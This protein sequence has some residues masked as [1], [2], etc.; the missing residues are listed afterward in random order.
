MFSVDWFR[1]KRVTVMGLGI[2]GGGVGIAKW[3]RRHGAFVT[4]T[5][6][7]DQ[8]ALASSI[9]ELERTYLEE[10]RKIG[11]SRLHRI[12][13]VLGA[14]PEDLFTGA[15]MVIRNPAVSRDHRLLALAKRNGVPV[16]SDISLFFMLC[17]FPI[18]GV[19]GTKGKTTTATMLAAMCKETDPRAVIGGNIRISPFDKLDR[20]LALA[21]KRKALPPPIVLELSSW[22]L[23]GL[24][25]HR[26]SPHV[27]VLT[28]IVEDHLDRYDGMDDY[29]RAKEICVAFQGKDDVA[30]LNADNPRTAAIGRWHGQI[31][32]APNAGRR[33]WFSVRV[34]TSGDGCYLAGGKIMLRDGRKRVAVA[35]VSSFKIPGAHN[36]SNVL[37]AVAAAHA[38]GIPLAAVRKVVRTFKGVPYRL[39]ETR[40]LRGVRFVNDTAATA[41]DASV[42]AMATHAGKKKRIVLISGGAD[43]NLPFGEW[44]GAVKKHVKHLVLFDGTATPKMEK[45]LAE[46]D[47]RTP[48]AGARSMREALAEAMRHARRGDVVLLS[49]GCASFGVFKN[50]FDRGDQF[51]ALVKKLR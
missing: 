21:K 3:L 23:E 18:A 25:P 46:A 19:S 38:M 33:L 24:E 31:K 15:D 39:E 30:V 22:Q 43:K 27:G 35:P 1:N 16:E 26:M 48:R 2:H 20:L 9:E 51:T 5:D 28:T 41:P 29:A 44:A 6:L 8:H 42:A 4:A 17:P 12:R 32:G 45:A 49:P 37:A 50:E 10:V 13:Y 7:R 40:M 14:H 11:K 36:R 47:A 34:L